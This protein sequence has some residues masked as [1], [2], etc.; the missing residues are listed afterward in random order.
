MS[1]NSVPSTTLPTLHN[2]WK[3][4]HVLSHSPTLTL[5]PSETL[6]FILWPIFLNYVQVLPLVTV[7]VRVQLGDCCFGCGCGPAAQLWH[8]GWSGRSQV[9]AGA[10]YLC[11]SWSDDLVMLHWPGPIWGAAMHLT[12]PPP[13]ARLTLWYSTSGRCI[14]VVPL[15]FQ[16][17]V[18]S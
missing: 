5:A 6:K 11:Q 10:L 16:S 3:F 4:L 12:L 14:S 7:W 13:G 15:A 8:S 1:D 2:T 17:H 9:W 18:C